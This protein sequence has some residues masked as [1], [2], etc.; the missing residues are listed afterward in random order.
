MYC[1]CLVTK[2]CPTLCNPMGCSPP[3]FSLHGIAQA[4][5]PEWVSISFSRGSSRPS[6]QTSVSCIGRRILHRWVKCLC[7]RQGNSWLDHVHVLGQWGHTG[8]ELLLNYRTWSFILQGAETWQCAGLGKGRKGPA[9]PGF[10][11]EDDQE[12]LFQ[13]ISSPR[14]S[15]GPA[16]HPSSAPCSGRWGTHSSLKSSVLHL[17]LSTAPRP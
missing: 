1:C 7:I 6:D 8:Q 2:S 13:L 10:D 15:S 16:M 3:G 14:H 4:R 17:L 11:L 5:T 12:I 9:Y